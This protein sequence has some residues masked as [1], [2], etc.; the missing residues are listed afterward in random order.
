V[1][2]L[3]LVK[4]KVE[5]SEHTGYSGHAWLAGAWTGEIIFLV[6]MAA[7]V[8]GLLA[9]TA[10]RS[11][12]SPVAMAIGTGVGVAAGLLMF[13]L[14]SMGRWPHI[15]IG[16]L[17]GVY[18]VARAPPTAGAATAD[19][20]ATTARIAAVRTK[21]GRSRCHIMGRTLGHPPLTGQ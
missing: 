5:R 10:R 2:A 11:P 12:F 6:V 18:S 8:A 21:P 19:K 17:A 9:L 13:A 3:V 16:W 7:Y 4:A 15:T 20:P 14:A 1:F